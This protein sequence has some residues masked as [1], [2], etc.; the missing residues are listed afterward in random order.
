M[1]FAATGKFVQLVGLILL[2]G[3]PFFAYGIARPAGLGPVRGGRVMAVAVAGW[4]L[5]AFAAA[6]DVYRI[7]KPLFPGMAPGEQWALVGSFL[8]H[9]AVGRWMAARLP[10]IGSA[11]RAAG[12]LD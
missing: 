8:R 7:L 11:S 3:W 12:A 9:T 5:V 6:L 2:V 4:L 10:A 1:G